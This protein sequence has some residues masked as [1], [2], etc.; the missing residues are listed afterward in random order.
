VA[1]S[2][3]F[4]ASR[5]DEQY[6]EFRFPVFRVAV[7]VL[8]VAGAWMAWESPVFFRVTVLVLMPVMVGASA[9]FIMV[10][11][12]EKPKSKKPLNFADGS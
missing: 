4:E 12:F 9:A 7:S 1:T 5:V 3:L 10:A 11:L 6:Y 2:W 8:V